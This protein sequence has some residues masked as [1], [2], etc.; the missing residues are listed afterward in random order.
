MKSWVFQGNKDSFV[1]VS[2]EALNMG[3][4][5]FTWATFLY[6]DVLRDGPL[7]EFPGSVGTKGT[8]MWIFKNRLF[9]DLMEK[10]TNNWLHFENSKP[11][12]GKWHFVGVSLSVKTSRLVMWVDGSVREPGPKSKPYA[13]S[14]SGPL[15][16]T[17]D[18]YIGLRPNDKQY[19]FTGKLAGTTMMNYFVDARKTDQLEALKRDIIKRAGM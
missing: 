18:L 5:D 1:K 9:F 2:G 6:Q 12:A 7:M 11:T 3:N 15:D 10:K 8:H 4:G 19:A 13:Y 17:G 16:M 14:R